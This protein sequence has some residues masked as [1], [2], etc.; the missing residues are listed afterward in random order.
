MLVTASCIYFIFDKL[1]SQTEYYCQCWHVDH[2]LVREVSSVNL[3]IFY[4]FETSISIKEAFK[5]VN[6]IRKFM[7]FR[8]ELHLLTALVVNEFLLRFELKD[9]TNS[10]PAL[11]FVML[12]LLT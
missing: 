2:I 3:I 5:T 10:L 6:I 9:Q 11:P 8:R 12:D 4:A 1:I 7:L